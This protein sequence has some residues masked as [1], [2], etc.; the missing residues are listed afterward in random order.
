[1]A[2]YDG[3]I[4]YQ[5][6]QGFIFEYSNTAGAT[7]TD[8]ANIYEQMGSYTEKLRSV[9][10][11]EEPYTH[12]ESSINLP[13]DTAYI[14][15]IKDTA[16]LYQSETLRYI[17]VIGIGGS[18]LGTKAVYDALYGSL[19]M[20]KPDR[21]PKIIF[22]ET[23]SPT[24]MIDLQFILSGLNSP[25]EILITV[26][27][28]SGGTTETISIFESVWAY[29][30]EVLGDIR[31]R[32]VMITDKDSGLWKNA[33]EKGIANLPVPAIVGGRYGVFSAMGLFPLAVAGVDILAFTE[34][35]RDMRDWC[36]GSANQYT[37]NY[38]CL[39]AGIIYINRQRG[40]RVNNNFFFNVQMESMGKWYRQL[41]GEG[42]G[43]EL[44]E[45]EEK[46]REG[47]LPIV[48][49]GSTDLHALGQLYLGMQT[50]ILTQFVYIP[51]DC[52]DI[53][54]P[55]DPFLTN[56]V[57][58]ATGKKFRTILDAILGGIKGAY[59]SK[60][61]PYSQITLTECSPYMLGLYMQFKMLEMM[62]LC[63]MLD[64]D[65]FS[66]P[67]VDDYKKITAEILQN[68]K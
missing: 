7:D 44:N 35:A 17:L 50:D 16:T 6:M 67:N 1:M 12:P 13:A 34:G 11:E 9:I 38:P 5:H 23:V 65:A 24:L 29:V 20:L 63:K 62:Y 49:I 45:K 64:V 42:T 19:D 4:I 26:I 14:N 59:I 61:M 41:M 46:I 39:G 31:S 2:C 58:M 54:V 57:P 32:I 21:L 15:T 40:I 22:L 27:S 3:R 18:N 66:Q 60:G 28:K 47:I 36:L 33:E 68:Q 10:A 37:D 8:L 25:E 52:P 30:H 48:S 53:A 55:V 51:E 56:L 43:K